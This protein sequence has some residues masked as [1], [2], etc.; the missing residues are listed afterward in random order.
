MSSCGD[1]WMIRNNGRGFLVGFWRRILGARGVLGH[2]CRM[3]YFVFSFDWF[4]RRS[5]LYLAR[6]E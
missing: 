2:G 5:M 3:R 6:L 4:L 1:S